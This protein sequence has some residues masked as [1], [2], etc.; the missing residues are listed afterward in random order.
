MFEH[1]NIKQYP[2]AGKTSRLAHTTTAHPSIH[3]RHSSDPHSKSYNPHHHPRPRHHP[4]HY[5][6]YLFFHS[7]YNGLVKR[8]D[9]NLAAIER[10]VEANDW[11][12]FLSGVRPL[13]FAEE[14][15]ERRPPYSYPPRTS[16]VRHSRPLL[17]SPAC[18][19][20]PTSRS[21]RTPPSAFLSPTSTPTA[22]RRWPPC[23]SRIKSRSISVSLILRRSRLVSLIPTL[24]CTS[25]P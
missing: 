4:H 15:A 22:S 13:K 16:P 9:A 5:R 1:E 12:S 24:T 18:R 20:S 6:S 19:R 14:F 7:R 21:A 8:A 17:M 3:A 2:V 10:F 25:Q 23:S 11:I